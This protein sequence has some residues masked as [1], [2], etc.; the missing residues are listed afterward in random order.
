MLRH[1]LS[2][3]PC[4]TIDCRLSPAINLP[5]IFQDGVSAY[6]RG[7]WEGK[8]KQIQCHVYTK[9]FQKWR[10]DFGSLAEATVAVSSLDGVFDIWKWISP[11][12]EEIH[13]HSNPNILLFHKNSKQSGNDIGHMMRFVNKK[14][15]E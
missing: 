3:R 2:I 9:L 11:A 5:N 13:N 1:L 8:K 7:T 10:R 6:L 12:L 15:T 14:L 4:R